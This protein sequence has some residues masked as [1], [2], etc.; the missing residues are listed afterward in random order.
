[1]N[2]GTLSAAKLE[3]RSALDGIFISYRRSDAA[4]YVGRISEKLA[5]KFRKRHVF[6]DLE[7][8]AAGTDFKSAIEDALS[9]SSVLL[10]VIGPGWLEAKD[11]NGQTRLSKTNDYVRLEIKTALDRKLKV[12]P[13]LVGG[14]KWPPQELPDD[15]QKLADLQAF[16]LSDIRWNYDLE[17][18]I[19]TIRQIV[20]PRYYLRQLVVAVAVLAA[21]I[22]VA[23]LGNRMADDRRIEQAIR[24]ARTKGLESDKKAALATLQSLEDTN[25]PERTNPKVY[26]YEAE[27][28]QMLAQSDDQ[29]NEAVKAASLADKDDVIVGRAKGLAC[30]AQFR[31]G[32]SGAEENCKA[33]IEAS[34][35]AKDPLGQARAINFQANILTKS[36]P[37]QALAGYRKA[38]KIASD[39]SLLLDMYGAYTNIAFILSTSN[40][41]KERDEANTNLEK[42]RKGFT[43]LGQFGEASNAYNNVGA[44]NL[45]A[46]R[47]PEAREYFQ[48][49]LNLALQGGDKAREA[50]VRLNQVQLFL[51]TGSLADAATEL[52]KIRDIYKTEVHRPGEV[53]FASAALGDVYLQQAEFEKARGAYRTAQG[54]Y[55]APNSKDVA[56]EALAAALLV[57]V[58][59]QEN[60]ANN[61]DLLSR[62]DQVIDKIHYVEGEGAR[63]SESFARIVKAKVLLK[64]LNKA[65][66]Q[67]EATKASN[68]AGSNQPDNENSANMVLAEI[69]AMNGFTKEALGELTTLKE[70]TQLDQGGHFEAQLLYDKV[71]KEAGG[72]EQRE[73]ADTLLQQLR[74]EAERM[75]FWLIV[76]KA[77]DVLARNSRVP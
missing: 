15:L 25:A 8:I 17:R 1:M 39:N 56:G 12:I 75:G 26:L 34:T 29:F 2:V 18:L 71:M 68:L 9:A 23:M 70:S 69:K 43:D 59:V 19:A 21:L 35:R 27:I 14:V 41:Q 28:Y 33:A 40:D 65:E 67:Q 52:N 53:A 37:D 58:D 50:Q 38:L 72:R 20:D 73:H 64:Q 24:D 46:G 60:K 47:F 11:A 42:A 57:N 49:A 7:T 30:D 22:A 16:E 32:L 45:E 13:V 74:E 6:R 62:I 76:G 4:G 44:N 61:S 36:N 5:K 51:Q 31:N 55:A 10:A 54:I 48:T 66:A 77:N 63:S 3:S